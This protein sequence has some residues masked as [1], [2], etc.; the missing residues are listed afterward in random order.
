MAKEETVITE[1]GKV[2]ER[3]MP[4]LDKTPDTDGLTEFSFDEVVNEMGNIDITFDIV[5]I[6]D[7]N[8]AGIKVATLQ[9]HNPE[10]TVYGSSKLVGESGELEPMIAHDVEHV[11][12]VSTDFKT[13]G[14]KAYK[15]ASGKISH[16]SY[17]GNK[18]FFDIAKS[19]GEVW[20]KSESFAVAGNNFRKKLNSERTNGVREKLRS[21]R[22]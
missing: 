22:P 11:K 21:R 12:I 16:G 2:E 13:E 6:E 4:V 9:L 19:D 5:K 17:K 7:T 8:T 15:D 1:T 18:L 14:L 20:L 3:V 10:E